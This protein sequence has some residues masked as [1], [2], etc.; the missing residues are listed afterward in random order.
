VLGQPLLIPQ[1]QDAAYGAALLTGIA[2]GLF[3]AS[4]QALQTLI[5]ISAHLEPDPYHHAIYNDLYEIY[6]EADKRLVEIAH[7]LTN[8]EQKYNP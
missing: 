1:E 8:F 3:D 6:L 4:P 7:H 2:A 5:Q